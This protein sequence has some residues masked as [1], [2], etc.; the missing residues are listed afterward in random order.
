MI[1]NGSQVQIHY[2][3]KVDDKVVDSSQGREPLAYVHGRKQI[4]SGLEDQLEGLKAGDK[5]HV[6]VAPDRGYGTR[7]PDAV[8]KVPRSAFKRPDEVKVGDRVSGQ[9][10]ENR[11]Q[12][13]VTEIASDQIT[14]DLNHPLAGKTLH[15]DVEVVNVS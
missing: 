10:G 3:L 6:T 15:F 2:T 12:A 9:S 14:L 4:I 11:F 8:R 5:K 7:N 1:Q 13:Q